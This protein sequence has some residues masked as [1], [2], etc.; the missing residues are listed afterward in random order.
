MEAWPSDLQHANTLPFWRDMEPGSSHR[1][2]RLSW[3]ECETLDDVAAAIA[4][5][6][7][8]VVLGTPCYAE[9]YTPERV[10]DGLGE[11]LGGH[12]W[13]VVGYD[14][15]SGVREWDLQSSWG[16]F[17]GRDGKCMFRASEEF[18][19]YSSERYFLDAIRPLDGV[20]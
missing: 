5:S 2:A 17:E 11:Y 4:F 14:H 13:T 7:R 12:A 20:E 18:M 6:K 16:P 3:R 10:M 1:V 8:A 9:I 19:Q 15:A